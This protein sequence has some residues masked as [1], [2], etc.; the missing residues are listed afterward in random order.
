MKKQRLC[1][2]LPVIMLAACGEKYAATND[3]HQETPPAPQI[4]KADDGQVV[5]RLMHSFRGSDD[6]CK[7]VGETSATSNYLDHTSWLVACPIDDASIDDI[8]NNMKG[9]VLEI[10]EGY[11]LLSVP[12][13]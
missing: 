5:L 3:M 2:L 6:P 4:I 11:V 7:T 1:L 13:N 9:Q 8:Q 10:L 12:R